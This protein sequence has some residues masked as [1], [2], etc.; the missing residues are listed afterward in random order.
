MRWQVVWCRIANAL[1]TLFVNGSAYDT[2]FFTAFNP[3]PNFPC[4][5]YCA[6]VTTNAAGTITGMNFF[7]TPSYLLGKSVGASL[8]SWSWNV[9]TPNMGL[10]ASGGA[11]NVSRVTPVPLPATSLLMVLGLV[12]LRT[13]SRGRA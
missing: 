5:E 6:E 3:T 2:T 10:F 4:T 8:A 11:L 1:F 7:G 9:F 12:A 13:A